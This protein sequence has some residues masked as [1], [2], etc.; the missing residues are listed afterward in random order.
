MASRLQQKLRDIGLALRVVLSG[1]FDP[2]AYGQKSPDLPKSNFMKTVH[3]CAFGRRENRA[4]DQGALSDWLLSHVLSKD[5]S[6]FSARKIARQLGSGSEDSRQVALEQFC[7]EYELQV[8]EYFY[9]L[10]YSDQDYEA[11]FARL[12]DLPMDISFAH[13]Y[14][15]ACKHMKFDRLEAAYEWGLSQLEAERP[16]GAE[17]YTALRDISAFFG[18]KLMP[19]EAL[20]GQILKHVASPAYVPA[21]SRLDDLWTIGF[22]ICP[23]D[24][25]L[26]RDILALMPDEL[27]DMIRIDTFETPHAARGWETML[28]VAVLNM[29]GASK[30][31]VRRAENSHE[32]IVEPFEDAS[33]P[34]ILHLRLLAHNHWRNT[35]DGSNASIYVEAFKQVVAA[36]GVSC[37]GFYP[38]VS[39]L[40]HDI[41]NDQITGLKT[42]SYHSVST[43]TRCAL[44]FKE[45][46]LPGFYTFDREGYSGWSS[47]RDRPMPNET[48]DLPEAEIRD[49][50]KALHDEYVTGRKTKYNQ[51]DT[52]WVRPDK[53]YTLLALQVPNDTV[54]SLAELPVA[55]VIEALTARYTDTDRL[56]IIKPHPFDV[57]K[58]TQEMIAAATAKST[59]ILVSNDSI[60]DLLDGAAIVV[61]TNSGVGFEALLRLKPV[62]TT[63]RS[64]YRAA[65]YP[66][67]SIPELAQK[68]DELEDQNHPAI[69]DL[70]IMQFLHA[71]LTEA[72]FT[73]TSIL[74]HFHTALKNLMTDSAD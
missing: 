43:Q 21:V 18:H 53:P 51:P 55:D 69:S 17:F 2:E 42:L 47:W 74:A 12:A 63:G 52:P 33:S 54:M 25:A 31:T 32:W 46:A 7:A 1:L 35:P 71:Y 28:N 14:A 50:Y 37:N 20:S 49:F 39:G 4:H 64:D 41:E 10:A 48:N 70:Q 5:V 30:R 57:S 45:S 62:I 22:P 16:R 66:A 68:L 6:P 44:H 13:E 61:T 60:H 23:D 19:T 26:F 56:L 72:C 9:H 29:L 11:A 67:G 59:N 58:K 65:T 3:Y 24:S 34:G 8:D 27:A 38:T 36:A 15:F 40:I 73:P